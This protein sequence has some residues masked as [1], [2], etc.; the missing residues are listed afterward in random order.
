MGSEIRTRHDD[1]VRILLIEDDPV[2]CFNTRSWLEDSGY[3]VDQTD[4]GAH[5]LALAREHDPDLVLCDL[6]MPGIDGLSVLQELS[7]VSPDLPVI[8][9]SG[10]GVLGDA[11]EALREG[12]WDFV[13]KPIQDMAVLEHAIEAALEKGRLIRQNRRYQH[14]LEQVNRTMREQLDRIEEDA[15]AG[16]RIQYQLMPREEKR[17]GQYSF[18]RCLLASTYLSGDFVDYFLIDPQHLGFF[19]ADVSG[20]GVSSAFVTVLLK[21][22]VQR[23]LERLHQD[24]DQTVLEPVRMLEALNENILRQQIDKYLTML[25]GVIERRTGHLRYANGGHFPSPVLVDRGEARFLSARAMP[26]GL[27]PHP[28]LDSGVLEL[29]PGSRLVLCSDGVLETCPGDSLDDRL[30]RLLDAAGGAP[31]NA[32]ELVER[33]GIDPERAYPDDITLLTVMREDSHA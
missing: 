18:S 7:A 24:G 8:V 3:T 15:D 22:F 13:V 31:A 14:E 19:I 1:P 4:D 16:R 9:V 29:A 5:G 2:V 33:L 27:F 11:V 10:T 21:S 32:A 26:I 20:H 25:Y 28:D 6:R 23:S 12:A 17:F 30:Q